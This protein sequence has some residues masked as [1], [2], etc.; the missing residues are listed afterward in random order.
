MI[1]NSIIAQLLEKPLIF[2]QKKQIFCAKTRSAS[3]PTLFVT[4]SQTALTLLMKLI[5]GI[6]QA[7]QEAAILKQ[8][9]ETGLWSVDSPKILKMTWIG[10]SVA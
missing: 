4:T 10:A 7:P 2:V 9:Q 8:L 1:L 5:V 3:H 6:T